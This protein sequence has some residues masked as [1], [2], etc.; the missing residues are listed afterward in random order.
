MA[1]RVPE[2]GWSPVHRTSTRS[3]AREVL[4]SSSSSYPLLGEWSNSQ[5][6]TVDMRTDALSPP[7]N[8]FYSHHG[9]L[10][11]LDGIA[12]SSNY[13]ETGGSSTGI[14]LSRA[15]QPSLHFHFG[16]FSIIFY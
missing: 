7:G 14:P 15:S 3:T 12:T 13:D 2:S 1:E 16:T 10:D 9:S 8:R 6:A 11:S 4:S 5:M